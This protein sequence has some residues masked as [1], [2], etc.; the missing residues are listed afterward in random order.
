MKKWILPDNK[1]HRKFNMWFASFVK[2]NE[3]FLKPA[4][5]LEA[6]YGVLHQT[7]FAG[8]RH[9]NNE[10]LEL[11]EI[12]KVLSHFVSCGVDYY[13]VFTQPLIKE[14]ML[15]DYWGNIQLQYAEKYKLKVLV[16]NN[17]LEKY[18]REKYSTINLISSTTKMNKLEKSINEIEK[19]YQVVIS[20]QENNNLDKIPPEAR[21]KIEILVNDCCPPDCIK[22]KY[23]Y[24]TTAKHN[25]GIINKA[26]PTCFNR[27]KQDY[28][29]TCNWQEKKEFLKHLFIND[30]DAAEKK[31]FQYFKLTGREATFSLHVSE[32]MY[33]MIEEEYKMPFIFNALMDLDL[34]HE[35]N[36]REFYMLFNATTEIPSIGDFPFFNKI[37]HS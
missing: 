28:L 17:T 12:E 20:T 4:T 10:N 29:N 2:K 23:C 13:L 14:E 26:E 31:G 37:E 21:N 35:K 3:E 18:I 9:T 7:I 16:A 32:I 30:V 24:V 8:G 27:L 15:N 22:R 36:N 6:F 1:Y 19:Y 34:L 25:F 5:S 33:Y 11:A